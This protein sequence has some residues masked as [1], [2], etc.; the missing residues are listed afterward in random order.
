MSQP[1]NNNSRSSFSDET[2]L[3]I[4]LVL[5]GLGIL[6][7]ITLV[8]FWLAGKLQFPPA[9]AAATAPATSFAP[10]I[11]VPTVD[12]GSP[13]LLLGLTALQ[14]QNISLGADGSVNVP[15]DGSR[16]AYWVE[17]NDQQ[18]IF[19]LS[20]T[21]ENL[22][23]LTSLSAGTTAKAT[24]SNCNSLTFTLSTPQP[25]DFETI[26]LADQTTARIVIYI[27]LDPTGEGFVITGGVTDP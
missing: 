19:I 25:G 17:G 23:L 5:M 26:Y 7:L 27:Q 15:P 11:F 21:P 6:L 2:K 18:Y 14:I 24:W 4:L 10:T 3:T 13:T 9:Q 1:P 8:V 20:P 16:I 12:C 22:A